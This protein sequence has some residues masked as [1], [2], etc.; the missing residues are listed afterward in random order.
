MKVE[1][2]SIFEEIKKMYDDLE[3]HCF[4]K[5]LKH[6]C[7][8]GGPQT[9]GASAT[10]EGGTAVDVRRF[11]GSEQNIIPMSSGFGRLDCN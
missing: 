9:R 6:F 11:F 7:C 3:F 5:M 2:T 4:K 1:G 8:T 10:R